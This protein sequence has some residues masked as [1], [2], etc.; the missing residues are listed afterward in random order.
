[1]KADLIVVGILLSMATFSFGIGYDMGKHNGYDRGIADMKAVAP[2]PAP[3]ITDQ[4]CVAWLFESNL[5]D[6]KKRV[7]K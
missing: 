1:M 7:C 6:V 5:K 2:P 3:R 4:Q